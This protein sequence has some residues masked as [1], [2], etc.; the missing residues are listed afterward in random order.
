MAVAGHYIITCT[1]TEDKILQKWES[2]WLKSMILPPPSHDKSWVPDRVHARSAQAYFAHDALTRDD[3]SF[4]VG[5]RYAPIEPVPHFDSQLG[6]RRAGLCATDTART[7]GVSDGSTLV[8]LVLG[9]TL[10]HHKAGLRPF[11]YLDNNN[12]DNHQ[13]DHTFMLMH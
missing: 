13:N 1:A 12:E 9:A 5:A 10:Q 7:H 11:L 2:A 6:A 3:K 8:Y 4:T